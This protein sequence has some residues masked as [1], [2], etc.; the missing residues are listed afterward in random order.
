MAGHGPVLSSKQ[1]GRLG[2]GL[3]AVLGCVF[4]CCRQPALKV[5]QLALEVLLLALK[6]LYERLKVWGRV[7]VG[8]QTLTEPSPP[9]GGHHGGVT[10]PAAVGNP[11]VRRTCGSF[12]ARGE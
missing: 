12:A 10:Q 4:L 6:V 5:S 7:F 1:L 8:V 3:P 11:F 2:G 9:L